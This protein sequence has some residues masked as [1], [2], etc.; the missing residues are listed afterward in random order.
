MA[1]PTARA[2]EHPTQ[3]GRGGPTKEAAMAAAHN[4]KQQRVGHGSPAKEVRH[5]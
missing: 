1:E 4:I 5:G 2:I 3:H